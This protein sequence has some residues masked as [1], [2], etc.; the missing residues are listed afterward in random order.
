MQNST[1]AFNEAF[2]NLHALI[3]DI[4]ST[5][6]KTDFFTCLGDIQVRA[7][8]DPFFHTIST[9]FMD[10]LRNINSIRNILIH[11][12]DWIEIPENTTNIVKN[13]A[14]AIALL[15]KNFQKKSI[16]VFGKNVYT[17][18]DSDTL[19]EVLKIM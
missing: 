14:Q 15:A 8:S 1:L 9:K 10:D 18:R 12:N 6:E 13:I 5:S 2:N 16:E 7:K 19:R 11:K 17:A 4:L 3:T